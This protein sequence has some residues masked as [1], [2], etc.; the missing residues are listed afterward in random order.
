MPSLRVVFQL[1]FWKTRRSKET[2]LKESEY[3][4]ILNFL[5][6][7]QYS[8]SVLTHILKKKIKREI[9]LHIKNN[10][11]FMFCWLHTLLSFQCQN[12]LELHD[13]NARAFGCSDYSRTS[14]HRQAKVYTCTQEMKEKAFCFLILV[15]FYLI[16]LFLFVC[17]YTW[18]TCAVMKVASFLK[19]CS[20]IIH[21]A[22][23]SFPSF[24]SWYQMYLIFN[25]VLSI[26]LKSEV[27]RY[28]T[29]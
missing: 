3:I 7:Q 25:S 5:L 8:A 13:E 11:V 18:K 27:C 10:V 12:P 1:H 14:P 24:G 26:N 23:S 9:K 19:S 15:A 17:F 21:V 16:N 4:W 2:A 29:C 28:S 6:Q 22:S 20:A